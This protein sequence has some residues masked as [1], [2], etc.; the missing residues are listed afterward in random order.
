MRYALGIDG[1]GS[2]C[3]AVLIDEEGT[4]AGW[5]RG[6]PTHLP[7][8]P[9]ALVDASYSQAIAGALAEAREAELYIAGRLRE[10]PPREAAAQVGRIVLHLEANEV[11][12]AFASV[13]QE[14]GI[15]VLS[16]TGSFVH[17]RTAD[18]RHLHFG[19]LGPVLGDY[20]S[21]YDIGLRG[22]RAAFASGWTAARRTTLA[23]AVPRALGVA[24]LRDVMRR[25]YVERMGRREIAAL[26]KIVDAEARKGDRVA[27]D[28]LVRSAEELA[29]VAIDLVKQL[30]LDE[31]AFPM[32]AIGSVAQHSDMWWQHICRR[33]REAAPRVRPLI[34]QFRPA[35]GA[36]LL[37][38]Q[39]MGV[40]WS[41][42]LLTRIGETQ[43]PFLEAADSADPHQSH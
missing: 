24:T 17:G 27:G 5:G 9:P 13:Q 42:A 37:A 16:G 30:E 22:A 43:Q 3:D 18:G 8:D 20:G 26:A 4:V 39:A 10:G 6:G 41:P 33:M 1:G 7:Y 31:V 38:L 40:S 14:W 34:P 25:V 36:A 23:E 2:K 12:T 32:I 15:V 19:G 35:V 28:C 11:D 21:A 29:E